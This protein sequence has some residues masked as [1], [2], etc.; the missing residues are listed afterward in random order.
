MRK[1]F[2]LTGI[3]LYFFI[4]N[5]DTQSYQQTENGVKAAINDLDVK[6]LFY[7][8]QIVRV[9]KSHRGIP[10][11]KASLSVVKEPE[12]LPSFPQKKSSY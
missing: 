3:A 9:L 12:K 4:I 10:F 8:P 1:Y 6:L 7:S 2:C 5:T 11:E